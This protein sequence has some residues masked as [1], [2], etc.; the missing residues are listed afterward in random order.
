M[1]HTSLT[2]HSPICYSHPITRV[3]WTGGSIA[4]VEQAVGEKETERTEELRWWGEG[5]IRLWEGPSRLE[6]GDFL[7]TP[8]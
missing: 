7:G 4:V 5:Q 2:L 3:D 6:L 8:L 1:W